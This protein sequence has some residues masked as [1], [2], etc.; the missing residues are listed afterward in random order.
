MSAGGAVTAVRY[1][2]HAG[3]N[4]AYRTG[5]SSSTV[6]FLVPDYQGSADTTVNAVDQDNWSVRRFA[7]FGNERSSPIFRKGGGG[8][9]Y[10][11]PPRAPSGGG[12][13]VGCNGSGGRNPVP[14]KKSCGWSCKVGKVGGFLKKHQATIA[15]IAAGGLCTAISS[16]TAVVGCAAIG[17]WVYG[18]QN[19]PSDQ[20][21]L[22]GG[23]KA[24]LTGAAIDAG[25]AVSGLLG[26]VSK[27]PRPCRANA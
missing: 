25:L 22:L 20:Q 8:G 18:H 11:A 4:V 14:V 10:L 15:G 27:S 19:T 12:C 7:P 24:G 26:P 16:G 17:G 1:Y 3:Q 13:W 21:T 2:R 5:V 9:V 6:Q 23:F